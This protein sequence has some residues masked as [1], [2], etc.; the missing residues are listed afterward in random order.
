MNKWRMLFFDWDEEPVYE[1]CMKIL[2]D[3]HISH[4]AEIVMDEYC[5][6]R[7]GCNEDTF[8]LIKRTLLESY[9]YNPEISGSSH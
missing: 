3:E 7:F 6:I 4:D 5:I 2:L 9:G 8:N 1:A